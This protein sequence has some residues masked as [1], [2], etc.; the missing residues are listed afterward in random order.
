MNKYVA[1]N[2]CPKSTYASR[3]IMKIV[4]ILFTASA[5]V[6]Q[7]NGGCKNNTCNIRPLAT[8]YQIDIHITELYVIWPL[9]PALWPLRWHE[10]FMKLFRCS[11]IPFSVL[12]FN[13]TYPIKRTHSHIHSHHICMFSF[14]WVVWWTNEQKRMN[15]PNNKYN[16][17]SVQQFSLM[18]IPLKPYLTCI[19]CALWKWV[20]E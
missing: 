15:N 7:H 13:Y 11:D 3:N 6:S 12:H 16:S 18:E 14:V 10:K 2:S 1:Q 20:S 4:F 5:N 17:R 19:V 9:I 8:M